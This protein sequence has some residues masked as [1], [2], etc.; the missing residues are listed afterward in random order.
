MKTYDVAIIGGGPAGTHAALEACKRGLSVLLL[1]RDV[2]GG[3]CLNR[4]CVPTKILLHAVKELRRIREDDPLFGIRVENVHI[5]LLALRRRIDRTV[6]RL[7]VGL[8]NQLKEAGADLVFETALNYSTNV[9]GTLQIR[10]EHGEF[11]ARN[12]GLAMGGENKVPPIAGLRNAVQKDIAVFSDRAWD[13]SA[14]P[15]RVAVIGSGAAGLEY[16]TIFAGL[17]SDVAL[18]EAMDRLGGKL[19]HPKVASHLKSAYE[20]RGIK[21]FLNTSIKEI[22][23]D[24]S[25][26]AAGKRMTFDRIVLALGTTPLAPSLLTDE[27]IVSLNDCSTRTNH[28]NVFVAGDISGDPMTADSA[29]V[30]G[31]VAIRNICGEHGVVPTDIPVKIYSDPE[32]LIEHH[33]IPDE[34]STIVR[35]EIIPLAWSKEYLLKHPKDQGF[36]IR[37]FP[38]ENNLLTSITIGEEIIF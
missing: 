23:S 19:L 2:V 3:V 38:A 33:C 13:F 27:N 36:K 26:L 11:S 7:R 15:M 10:C 35:E 22:T 17:G 14:V 18:F 32:I 4:G 20:K 25:L 5:D 31:I 9:A 24:G 21:V 6:I 12:L 1:E 30:E 37:T 16:A 34:S 8:E 29:E 28:P